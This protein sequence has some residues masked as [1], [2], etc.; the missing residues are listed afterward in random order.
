MHNRAS[1]YMFFGER[2][3]AREGFEE[4]LKINPNLWMSYLKLA[5]L[6]ESYDDWDMAIVHASKALEIV[7]IPDIRRYIELLKQKA[8]QK[9]KNP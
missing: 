6:D 8:E 3:K 4:A 7:D 2:E 1:T 9:Q 5:F